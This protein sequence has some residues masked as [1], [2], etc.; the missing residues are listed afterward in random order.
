MLLASILMY[1]VV[2][3]SA[4]SSTVFSGTTAIQDTNPGATF[5]LPGINIPFI[6]GIIALFG[7]SCSS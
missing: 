4:L 7:H 1:G 6:E 5:L 2:V 3:L